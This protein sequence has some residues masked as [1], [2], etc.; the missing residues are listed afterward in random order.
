[1]NRFIILEG[2]SGTGKTTIGKLLAEKLGA[3]FYTTPSYPFDC[4]REQI[5]QNA[6]DVSRFLFYLASVFYASRQILRVLKDKSVVCDRYILT[7][8][9]YHRI[10]GI[11]T[12]IPESFFRLLTK[13]DYT[14]LIV[15]REDKRI[16]R[17]NRRGLTQNDIVERKLRIDQRF[18]NEYRKH[19]LIEIDNSEDDPMLAVKKIMSLLKG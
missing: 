4:I 11:D 15:C 5:D 6:N 13:P 17:L 10:L 3:F 18:L 9:C 8:T 12:T 7:T 16:K 19:R 14:F 1:M 2:L